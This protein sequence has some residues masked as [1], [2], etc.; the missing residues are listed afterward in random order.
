MSHPFS[1]RRWRKQLTDALEKAIAP[2]EKIDTWVH[3]YFKDFLLFSKVSSYDIRKKLKSPQ[4]CYQAGLDAGLTSPQFNY[5]SRDILRGL[6]QSTKDCTLALEYW[7]DDCFAPHADTIVSRVLRDPEETFTACGTWHSARR[8]VP[9]REQVTATLRASPPWAYHAHRQ[10]RALGAVNPGHV[11]PFGELLAPE[12]EGIYAYYDALRETDHLLAFLQLS[13]RLPADELIRLPYPE[14]RPVALAYEFATQ[15]GQQDAF[16]NGLRHSIADGTTRP[17]AQAIL[18][19]FQ[20][21]IA[22]AR[23][24]ERRVA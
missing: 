11:R 22:Q 5:L 21:D 24:I 16:A 3:D 7:R 4:S 14:F 6:T 23:T 12:H 13:K 2:F 10:A 1:G 19:Y 17:W 15:T 18:D 8:L 9:Y 20:R